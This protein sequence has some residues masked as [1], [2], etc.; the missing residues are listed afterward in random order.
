[1]PLVG[2]LINREMGKAYPQVSLASKLTSNPKFVLTAAVIF[3]IVAWP[4]SS[5][6]TTSVKTSGAEQAIPVVPLPSSGGAEACPLHG[7]RYGIMMDAGS[8]GSRTHIFEFDIQPNGQMK[9]VREVFE[10][11]KP[12]LS[13]FA[14]NPEGAAT[15]LIP[16]MEAAVKSVPA[17]AVPCTPVALKATAGLRLLGQ[18]PSDAIL[19]AVSKLFGKYKFVAGADA[20][21]VMDSKDEGPYAWLT[22]NFLLETL[23]PGKKT[24]AILDLGGG[25][26][27]I[28]FVPDDASKLTNAPKENLYVAKVNGATFQAYQHSHL[29]LGLKE[30]AKA[31]VKAAAKATSPFACFPADHTETVDET[32]VKTESGK[33]SF[34]ECRAFIVDT[35]FKKD[36][37]A[38]SHKPCAIGG[39]FQPSL[40]ESFSGPIYAFSYFYDR[41]EAHLP[42]SGEITVGE[43]KRVGKQ[44][45]EGSN[46]DQAI[47]N[48]GTMC[49]DL[50]FLHAILSEGYS[51]PDSQTL[52][53]K[54]KING[55]ET[56][57]AL[58]AMIVEM[59]L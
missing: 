34:D 49:M 1:M 6:T 33:Q 14:T 22:V 45:C 56:A 18:G 53:I 24:A 30:A 52:H 47:K 5:T 11:L 35:L 58:G 7:V 29:G 8:T 54:K 15:S 44:V 21:I 51:L 59:M 10:E 25:S 16:L 28:V 57:W 50:A 9:L 23:A 4:R 38:C 13:S 46:G 12:G 27:Q 2:L 32:V 17:P 20:A 40:A 26:T 55:I 42:E 48:K 43:Y 39:V 3:F 41:M 36:E 37:A 31:I 19:A